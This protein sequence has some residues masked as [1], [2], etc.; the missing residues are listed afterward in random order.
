MKWI[1]AKPLEGFSSLHEG[2]LWNFLGLKIGRFSSVISFNVETDLPREAISTLIFHSHPLDHPIRVPRVDF[3][4]DEL[5]QWALDLTPFKSFT[6][7]LNQLNYKQRYNYA[8]TEKCFTNCGCSMT[9]IEGDW[10]DYAERAYEL[11]SNVA[12]KYMQI[13]DLGFF[14]AIA[15]SPTHKLLCARHGQKLIG[16]LVM[17][18]EV[19]TIHSMGCGLDYVH[20]KKSF[21]YSKLHYEF[22]RH[23][24]AAGKFKVADAGITAD[25][26]KKIL[27]LS[28]KPAVIE[29][30]ADSA[31]LR[32][33][34]RLA[35][36]FLK[37]SLNTRNEV[38]FSVRWPKRIPK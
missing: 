5:T 37:I 13:Y 36:L 28:P 38:R 22:I 35:H 26:A 7:Y 17:A 31:L 30:S 6:D 27:G 18:E 11:Y 12:A 19:S 24:V 23:A 20:S 15:K 21:T 32:T 25:Q 14:R 1:S 29:I 4:I 2:M 10:S 34:L 8:R 3:C 9:I 16:T 33:L